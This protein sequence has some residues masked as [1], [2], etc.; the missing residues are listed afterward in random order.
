MTVPSG[1]DHQLLLA[2]LTPGIWSIRGQHDKAQ[3]NA[4]VEAGRNT[5]FFV[6]PGDRYTVQPEAIPGAPEFQA[7][8][9]FMPALSAETANAKSS[10]SQ[11]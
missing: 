6:V 4:K 3:F 10:G 1:R 9:D 8:P 2:G 7:A 11:K 5:A